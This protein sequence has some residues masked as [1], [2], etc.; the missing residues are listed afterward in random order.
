M[1]DETPKK[2]LSTFENATEMR[3]DVQTTVF[4]EDLEEIKRAIEEDCG[5]IYESEW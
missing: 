3:H 4:I 1:A 5:K 2:I